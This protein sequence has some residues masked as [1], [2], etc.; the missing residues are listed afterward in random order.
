MHHVALD[1]ARAARSPPRSPGRRSSPASCRGSIAICARDLDLEHADGVGALDHRVGGRVLGRD[2]RQASGRGRGAARSRSR[3]L[4]TQVSMPSARQSTLSRPSAS[5]SSLSHWM[6]VRS[7][8]AAFSTGTRC[9]QRRVGDHEAA[10]V[11]RQVAREVEQ[12][13]RSARSTR[14]STGLVRVEAALAQALVERRRRRPTRRSTLASWST[15]SGG[16]PSALRHVA[17]RALAAVAD[18]RR[19]QRG[20]LAAVLA[21]DVLDH[22]LAPLVLEVDVDVRRL[23]ALLAR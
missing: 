10:G 12:F 20:A 1:R 11:L 17:H 15:W 16:R 13:A 18:H 2:R 4:R 14:R 23:V 22:F 8:M 7:G 6:M 3:H 19:G 9:V 5:R 21:V